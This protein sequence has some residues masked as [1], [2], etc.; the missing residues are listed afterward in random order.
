MADDLIERLRG[1]TMRFDWRDIPDDALVPAVPLLREA[2]DALA[3]KDK[4][5][6]EMRAELERA[7]KALEPF[8]EAAASYEPDEGDDRCIAWAHDFT[9]GSLRRAARAQAEGETP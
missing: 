8:A 2:A 1:G 6:K 5:L 3:S 9:I 7:R 4:A